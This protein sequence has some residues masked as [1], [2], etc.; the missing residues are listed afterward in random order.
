MV[1]NPNGDQ[2]PVQ[3]AAM[4]IASRNC[5]LSVGAQES[6]NKSITK[7]QQ[8]QPNYGRNGNVKAAET[9]F[10]RMSHKNTITWTAMIRG[11]AKDGR[12]GKAI[13]LFNMLK[14]KDDF[15]WIVIISGFVSNDEFEEALRWYVRMNQEGCGP[16]P[17]TISSSFASSAALAALNEGLQ[18]HSHVLKMNLEHDLSIQNSLISFYAKC[19]NVTDA[20]KI[21]INVDEPNVVSC[22]SVVNGFA[23]NG[24]G[25]EALDIYKR[26]QNE[27]LEHNHV[28][29][30]AV[31]SAC[32]HAGLIEEEG[33]NLFNTTESNQRSP[34]T[35]V[36]KNNYWVG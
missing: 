15:V 36:N 7:S 2:N 17:V 12:I 24:F 13:E 30:L 18:I 20:Y 14:E 32:T 21:F 25:E 19:G 1:H 34:I 22:N 6:C 23:Q 26:M 35:A 33:W 3:A 16:N 28:T 4:R 31:L 27:S 10:H 11:F 29:F 5:M 9:I 8:H